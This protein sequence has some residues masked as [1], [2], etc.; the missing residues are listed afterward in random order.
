MDACL[1]RHDSGG[2]SPTLHKDTAKMAVAQL[3][4]MEG[5]RHR[6][7]VSQTD[8]ATRRKETACATS[9]IPYKL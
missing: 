9:C 1:R 8:A 4:M 6:L 3:C 5:V 2:A 7:F